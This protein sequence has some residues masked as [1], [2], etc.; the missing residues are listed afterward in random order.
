MARPRRDRN[1]EK[2]AITAAASRLL[3]GIPLRSETGKLTATELITESGLRRD[4]VYEHDK[5][6]HVVQDFLARAKA[7]HAV[8]EAMQ[9]LT[10]DQDRLRQELA[11]TRATL[12]AERGKVKTLMKIATELSL[13]L[14]Q[15]RDE[16]AA[17]SQ[18]TRLP[19]RRR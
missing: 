18:L 9:Q 2:A 3:A 13:E 17:A 11:E 1:A 19:P 4:V 8:P 14:Q 10:D 5:T 16:L 6:H 7:Q 15:A 12:A